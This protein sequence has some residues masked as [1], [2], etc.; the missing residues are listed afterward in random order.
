MVVLFRFSRPQSARTISPPPVYVSQR[1]P[2][3]DPELSPSNRARDLL[4]R[5]TLEQ[6]VGQMIQSDGRKQAEEQVLTQRVGSF[7]HILGEPTVKLQKL[8]EETGLGIPLIFGIDAIHGHGFWPG[9]TVF[10]TQL[11]LSCAWNPELCEIMGRVTAREMAATGLHWTFSPVLCLTRD[12][13]WGR[14]GETFGED[15]F[16]LGQLGKGLLRGYQGRNLSDPNSVLACAKHYAGYSETV[17]GRDA[18]EAEISERKLRTYFLPPFREMV[19]AGCRSFM[20]A[21]QCIDGVAC[22]VNRWLLTEVLRDEWGFE[23]FVITDWNNVGRAHTEQRLYPSVEAVVPDAVRAGN[24]MIMCTAE[25]YE[26]ALSQVRKGNLDPV[27]IE[28]CSRR[29]LEHKFALGLFDHK[30]YPPIE[31]AAEVVGC[32]EHRESLL[33]SALESIVLLKNGSAPGPPTLPFGPNL[34]RIAVVGPNADDALAQL[35]D[36]SF[37]SGQAGL[38]TQGHP[39][40][41]IS[42]VLDGI[43][44]RADKGSVIIDYARGCDI[45]SS[46]SSGITEAARLAGAADVAIAVV[47]DELSQIGETNDRSELE[48]SGGQIPLLKALK[49]T[50]TPLV[51]VLINSKPLCIPWV[52][53]QADAVLEAFNPGMRGGEAIARILFGDANPMGKLTISF[54]RAVGEQP[55]YYQQIPGWHGSRNGFYNTEA[56]YPFGY[57]LSYTT[58]TYGNLKLERARIKR[59]QTVTVYVDVTNTGRRAGT[60]IVQLYLNDVYSTLST[61]NKSLKDFRRL[62]LEPS[63]TKRVR[64]EVEFEALG[65][66]DQKGQLVVEP[67]EF[68]ILVGSSSRDQDLLR[69]RFEIEPD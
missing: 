35:G 39:R 5:M 22:V 42:T 46:H 12:L 60:E 13:R 33:Q 6:K 58:F 1:L 25:F 4:G 44:E 19:R 64:F 49:A 15:P 67:G 23:G 65:F 3:Q 59:G 56:L 41:L 7:L 50:G 36:W 18:S 17:G 52:A 27:D 11:A 20:T 21:Y 55:V 38:T 69:A 48:L 37:G 51:V 43:R 32:A 29:I 63:Q 34:R 10:P 47:G 62:S 24:D 9:A 61:P 8:A 54:P 53:E 45:L 30:R 14:V 66:I 68:E 40:H 16:L 26:A 2:Y 28:R 57:G 31:T